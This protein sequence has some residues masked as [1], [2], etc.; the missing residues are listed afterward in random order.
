MKIDGRCLTIPEF[1]QYVDSLTNMSPPIAI[2]LHH[3]WKPTTQGWGGKRTIRAMANFYEQKMGW[4]AGPH[5]FVAPDGIWLFTPLDRDGIGVKGHNKWTKHIEMVGNY[6]TKLPEGAILENTIA[7]LGYLLYKFG[8]P[9][10]N[11]LFHRDFSFKTCPGKM[12]TKE[13][14]Y[15]KVG[16]WIEKYITETIKRKIDAYSG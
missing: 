10:Q 5:V 14:I 7:V 2:F 1:I 8:L 9:M 15:P 6:D 12:V 16:L 4:D 13:W 11:L 3:T